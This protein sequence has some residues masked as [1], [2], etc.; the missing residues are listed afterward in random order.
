M[1]VPKYSLSLAPSRLMQTSRASSS[2]VNRAAPLYQNRS[3]RHRGFGL[4]QRHHSLFQLNKRIR[5]ATAQYLYLLALRHGFTLYYTVVDP[6]PIRTSPLNESKERNIQKTKPTPPDFRRVRTMLTYM[7]TPSATY[8]VQ[9][10]CRLT[11]PHAQT[12][13]KLVIPRPS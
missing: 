7:C 9:I 10:K 1:H 12:G 11:S 6:L 13:S 5:R 2:F 3:I 4:G 8:H